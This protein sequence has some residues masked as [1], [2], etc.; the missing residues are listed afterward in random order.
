[1][2]LPPGGEVYYER[3][4]VFCDRHVLVCV[5]RGIN[6]LYKAAPGSSCSATRL[7]QCTSAA[8]R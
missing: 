4:V 6:I 7:L 8:Y 1:V 2:I 5:E 3:F